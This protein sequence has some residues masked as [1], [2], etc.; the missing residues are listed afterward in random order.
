MKQQRGYGTGPGSLSNLGQLCRVTRTVVKREQSA[1]GVPGRKI[2][3]SERVLGM[4]IF[5]KDW[6]PISKKVVFQEE[7]CAEDSLALP[8]SKPSVAW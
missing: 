6:A 1:T 5:A 8:T 3:S 2:G 7:R 4:V